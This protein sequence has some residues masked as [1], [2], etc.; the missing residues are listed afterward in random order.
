MDVL[1]AETL[2]LQLEWAARNTPKMERRGVLVRTEIPQRI[3]AHVDELAATIGVPLLDLGVEGKDGTGLKTEIPWVRVFSRAE[4]PRATSGWYLVYLFSADGERVYLSLNQGTTVWTG[5]DFAPREPAEIKARVA[6]ARPRI[7]GLL[8]EWG[9]VQTDIKLAARKSRLGEGYEAGNVTAI[10]Y[11]RDA[12]PSESAFMDDLLYMAHLLR[13]LYKAGK[14]ASYVPGDTPPEVLEAEE[15][16]VKAARRRTVRA[17]GQGI[18]LNEQERRA[19]ERH[20]VSMATDYFEAQGWSVKDVGL[21]ESYDLL[22]SRGDERLHVEVKG[23]T[24]RGEQV[25]L[26]RAEVARQRALVPHNALVVV[27]SIELDRTA[28]PVSAIGGT[29]CC[30][31]PWYIEDEDLSVVS[32]VYKTGL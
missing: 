29:L 25:V 20:S 27:H 6:W 3:R 12:L 15:D 4:S 1:F 18:R 14:T 9:G 32:Y 5:T 21:K 19:L 26:T 31:S 16:A 30:T 10:E 17:R 23:T 8:S 24:S 28:K 11:R 7:E 13:V 2:D 22:L